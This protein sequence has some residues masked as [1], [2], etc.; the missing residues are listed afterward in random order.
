M[1]DTLNKELDTLGEELMAEAIQ[2]DAEELA[3]TYENNP[4]EL[5]DASQDGVEQAVLSDDSDADTETTEQDKSD[6]AD[7]SVNEDEE[8]KE[9]TEEPETTKEPVE[10]VAK[11][12][13]E[14]EETASKT[15]EQ[16]NNDRYDRNW[17]KFQ[18]EKATARSEIDAERE[19]LAKMREELD[20]IK[21]EQAESKRPPTSKE[22]MDLAKYYEDKGEYEKAE[23]A[24]TASDAQRQEEV[25]RLE[26]LQGATETPQVDEKVWWENAGKVINSS[27]NKDLG[28]A[29]SEIGKRIKGLLD[30]DPRFMQQE[31]GFALATH[32]AE[33]E[34]ASASLADKDARIAELTKEISKYKKLTAVGASGANS[35]PTTPANTNKSID[36]ELN[37][38][39]ALAHREDAMGIV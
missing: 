32:I 16:K 38:M 37:E 4:E 39:M 33:G 6:D 7:L 19:E 36:Q 26:E 12:T 11:E 34:I 31:D 8:T 29:S 1:E 9:V 17:K 28:D 21:A 3:Q 2:A 27:S 30:S 15:K 25:Q 22:Y 5:I 35:H 13:E 18:E 14:A 23:E 10:E 24:K 20:A